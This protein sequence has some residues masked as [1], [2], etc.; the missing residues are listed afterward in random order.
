MLCYFPQS[1]TSVRSQCSGWE[2]PLLGS[3]LRSAPC[4]FFFFFSPLNIQLR[5]LLCPLGKKKSNHHFPIE[6]FLYCYDDAVDERLLLITTTAI[7]SSSSFTNPCVFYGRDEPHMLCWR[8]LLYWLIPSLV[9]GARNH[10]IYMR[11]VVRKHFH[12]VW[13]VR[14]KSREGVC[15]DR[16][17][18]LYSFLVF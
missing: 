1:V 9:W 17:F 18:K 6:H 3:H 14:G 2:A 12:S 10:S 4:V 16:T 7:F 11:T 13:T 15:T 5:P 8:L